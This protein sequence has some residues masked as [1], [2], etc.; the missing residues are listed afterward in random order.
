MAV[1]F[2]ISNVF[3]T[4]IFTANQALLVK[5][6]VDCTHSRGLFLGVQAFSSSCGVL[7]IDGLGGHIYDF[8][9]RNPYYICM[10]STSLV[11]FVCIVLSL[12]R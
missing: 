8:D 5:S 6:I 4:A 1:G 12:C 2:I 3:S 7:L 11:I 10:G 9:K